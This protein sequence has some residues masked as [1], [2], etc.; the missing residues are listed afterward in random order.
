MTN[1]GAETHCCRPCHRRNKRMWRRD[2]CDE[3]LQQGPSL[4]LR[5]QH[6]GKR[7]SVY[8]RRLEVVYPAVQQQ[9][10][11]FT[12]LVLYATAIAA[13]PQAELGGACRRPEQPADIAVE[14]RKH[15]FEIAL[16]ASNS[17]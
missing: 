14:A 15:R 9:K 13:P 12:Q 4:Q 7:P 6:E 5:S 11:V 16:N 2:S 17:I 10:P 1:V 3:R 8:Q